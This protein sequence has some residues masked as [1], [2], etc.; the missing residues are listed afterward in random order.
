[1]K[2]SIAALVLAGTIVLAGTAPAVASTTYPAPGNEY[3]TVSD[4]TISR[5]ESITFSGSGYIAGETV[6]ITF[7]RTGGKKAS[8]GGRPAPSNFSVIADGTGAF[9]T[10]ITFTDGG[11]YMIG[12]VGATSGNRRWAAV[13]VNSG[14]GGG[15]NNGG[16]NHGGGNGKGNS[17]LAAV[18]SVTAAGTA[19]GE[20]NTVAESNLILWSL[21]GAGALAASAASTA[22][23]RRRAKK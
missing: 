22:V 23:I 19:N 20:A 14:N 5:G 10:P 13:V 12:A 18:S 2:K 8:D 21:V 17:G 15:N 16:G 9:S 3:G 1:M 4:G 11:N 7:E 6:N